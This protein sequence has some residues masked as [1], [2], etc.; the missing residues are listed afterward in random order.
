MVGCMAGSL[1]RLMIG[2]VAGF[3]VLFIDVF[4]FCSKVRLVARFMVGGAGAFECSFRGWLR[5][6]FHGWCHIGLHNGAHWGS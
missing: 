2:S 6:W 3:M 4:M 1:V 5:G